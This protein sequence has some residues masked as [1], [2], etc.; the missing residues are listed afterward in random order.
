MVTL[1]ESVVIIMIGALVIGAPLAYGLALLTSRQPPRW[2]AAFGR[3]R[4]S[5]T[6][7]GPA[8]LGATPVAFS[9][10]VIFNVINIQHPGVGPTSPPK[11]GTNARPSIAPPRAA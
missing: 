7:I 4:R 8:S 1:L 3:P 9:T 11:T 6:V 5:P 10:A 2:T